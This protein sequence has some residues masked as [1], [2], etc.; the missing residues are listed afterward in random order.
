MT[1]NEKPRDRIH[2]ASPV[3]IWVWTYQWIDNQNVP[4]NINMG[5]DISVD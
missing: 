3:Q 1:E 5:V 4:L 2:K